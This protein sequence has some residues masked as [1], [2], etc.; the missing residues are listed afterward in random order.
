[1]LIPQRS[2]VRRFDAQSQGFTRSSWLS[3]RSGLPQVQGPEGNST[4]L[5]VMATRRQDNFATGRVTSRLN[6][7]RKLIQI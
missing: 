7:T 1:M 5:R 4:E 6:E 2:S 3:A